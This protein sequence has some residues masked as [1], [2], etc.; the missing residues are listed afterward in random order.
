MSNTIQFCKGKN[1]CPEVEFMENDIV[2]L[3][4][5]NDKEGATYWTKDQFKDFIDSVNNGDFD[6]FLN[7]EPKRKD[8]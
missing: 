8:F 7:N 4:N 1:C 6:K 2:K 3:G 5:E